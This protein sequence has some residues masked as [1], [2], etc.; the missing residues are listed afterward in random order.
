MRKLA[1][2]IS[3]SKRANLDVK[4]VFC[5]LVDEG[6][7]LARISEQALA[8]RFCSSVGT[9]SRWRNGQAAPAKASRKYVI[10]FLVESAKKA[11]EP[12]AFSVEVDRESVIRLEKP[13][14]LIGCSCGL[15]TK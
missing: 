9:V 5:S 6:L 10:D 7:R 8:E 12:R 11:H 15:D 13:I 4:Q 1:D 2:Y 14:A 3:L